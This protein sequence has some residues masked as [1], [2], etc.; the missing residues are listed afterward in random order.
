MFT[1]STLNH[2]YKSKPF[3]PQN[4]IYL[5]ITVDKSNRVPRPSTAKRLIS[6]TD[7]QQDLGARLL[8]SQKRQKPSTLS[9][10]LLVLPFLNKSL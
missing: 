9:C 6:V 5:D 4:D 8:L 10:F 3:I 2:F 7:T 1:D